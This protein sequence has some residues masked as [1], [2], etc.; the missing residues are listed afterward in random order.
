MLCTLGFPGTLPGG[1]SQAFPFINKKPPPGRGRRIFTSDTPEGKPYEEDTTKP[2]G[3]YYKIGVVLLLALYM[4]LL[5]NLFW[6]KKKQRKASRALKAQL[7]EARL[8]QACGIAQY[9]DNV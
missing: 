2:T 8:K 6:Q 9:S 7:E 5:G 1:L 3:I 4:V